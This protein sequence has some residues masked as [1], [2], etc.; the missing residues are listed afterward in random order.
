MN[1]LPAFLQPLTRFFDDLPDQRSSGILGQKLHL[2]LKSKYDRIRGE[3]IL[4]A[5]YHQQ[6]LLLFTKNQLLTATL[7][8][9]SDAIT[10]QMISNNYNFQPDDSLSFAECVKANPSPL[11]ASLN[12]PKQSLQTHLQKLLS[13]EQIQSDFGQQYKSQGFP[14]YYQRHC[15][16]QTLKLLHGRTSPTKALIVLPTGSGKTRTAL[17]VLIDLIRLEYAEH[18]LWAVES[19]LLAEQALQSFKTLYQ[20][21]GDMEISVQRLYDKHTPSS[22]QRGCVTFAG[23][24]KLYSLQRSQQATFRQLVES[25]THLIID[26]AHYSLAETYAQVI[27][28]FRLSCNLIGLT[29]TPYRNDDHNHSNLKQYFNNEII[30]HE[31]GR[32]YSG[33]LDQL[34]QEEYLA[35]LKI[36]Y[37]QIPP[38]ELH[39][40]SSEFNE[41]II[42][43]LLNLANR[44]LKT[45]VFACS[46]DHAI[47]LSIFLSERNTPSFVITGDTHFSER[48]P[49]FDQFMDNQHPSNI[50]INYEILATGVDLPQ[51]D[52]IFIARTFKNPVTAMQ[53]LGR[54]L[55]GPKNG[56]KKENFVYSVRS[57]EQYMNSPD[58]LYDLLK[59]MTLPWQA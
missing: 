18:I 56:G 38:I 5:E 52:G 30:T 7:Y 22:F 46:K 36:H 19:P 10:K 15:K 45:L 2:L 4:F 20:A 31:Y 47:A 49:I 6:G 37:L 41:V 55:R 1:N 17:E 53:V 27:Q 28:P 32:E 40:H 23:F 12:A 50:L 42:D 3:H 48:T 33:S 9:K 39:E 58:D 35:C 16:I 59:N 44:K 24:Q 14:H 13:K 43:Q 25:T 51:I 11:Y 57:N 34:Q 8:D 26:E 54:A 21:K 29:A